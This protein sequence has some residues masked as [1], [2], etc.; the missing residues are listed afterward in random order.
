[1]SRPALWFGLLG[2][3]VAWTVHLIA[4]VAVAEFGCIGQLGAH[5]YLGVT[6]VAWMVLAL[7]AVTTVASA[8]ATIVAC[9]GYRRLR[10]KAA[11]RTDL[12]I[13]RYAARVGGLTSGTF[14]FVIL[15]ETIP[16]FYYL[17]CC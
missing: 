2:G 10:D 5:S 12:A 6:L 16:V 3:G 14:T 9:R 4:A 15:F 17:H 11:A 13:E 8:W 1:M 7:T